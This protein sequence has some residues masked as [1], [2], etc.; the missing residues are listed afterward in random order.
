MITRKDFQKLDGLMYLLSVASNGSKRKV[1]ESLGTSVDTV[2]KYLDLL[3]KEYG[4]NL[5]INTGHG[6]ILTPQAQK[7][8]DEAIS[9]NKILTNLNSISYD[10]TCVTGSVSLCLS[11][12]TSVYMMPQNIV[13]FF[14]TYQQLKIEINVDNELSN[15]R[16]L[17]SDVFLTTTPL[18]SGDIILINSKEIKCGFFAS[19]SYIDTYGKPQNLDDL[20]NNHK[21]VSKINH[22]L[23]IPGWKEVIR[24][25]KNLV[26]TTN[27]VFALRAMIENGAGIGIAPLR[28]DSDRLVHID[29]IDYEVSVMLY[30]MAHRTTKDLP[31]IQ[32]LIS[33]LNGLLGQI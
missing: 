19:Q 12:G 15:F 10:N 23:F 32:A 11:E 28:T 6:S 7:M 29:T 25:S 17:G 8:I 31:R 3:E 18:E 13:E 2:N 9:I 22:N 26:C 21:I 14:S 5:L 20:L 24:K 4:V 16:N 27:S 1:A 30:L 33:Y